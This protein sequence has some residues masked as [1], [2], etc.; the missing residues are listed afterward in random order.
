MEK[1]SIGLSIA[2]RLPLC[3]NVRNVDR[4]ETY[5]P[6]VE[7]SRH[8]VMPSLR[9]RAVLDCTEENY[10]SQK[11]EKETR[12][13]R[14]YVGKRPIACDFRNMHPSLEG[15]NSRGTC[16][17]PRPTTPRDLAKRNHHSDHVD[18][19]DWPGLQQESHVRTARAGLSNVHRAGQEGREGNGQTPL[20]TSAGGDVCGRWRIADKPLSLLPDTVWRRPAPLFMP[21]TLQAVWGD[22]CRATESWL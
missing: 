14:G 11:R 4:S 9:G 12:R 21:C 20:S 19:G 22:D 7:Y 13:Q 3:H 1:I 15:Q 2:R 17:G 6:L 5:R 16:H 8:T 10:L 18:S